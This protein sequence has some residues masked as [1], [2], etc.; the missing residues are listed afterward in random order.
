LELKIGQ[1]VKSRAGRD[2]GKHYLVV[3]LEGNWVLLANGRCRL[4]GKPKK[5][6]PKHLQPYR[7]VIEEVKG[8]L[9]GGNLSDAVLR[10]HL[11]SFASAESH[12]SHYRR[13]S[14]TPG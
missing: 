4:L 9:Q 7:F 2:K 14:S 12:S 11:N 3:G 5:K 1:V 13:T 8:R 10:E 6:N